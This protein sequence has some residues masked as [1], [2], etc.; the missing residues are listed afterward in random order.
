MGA[1]RHNQ[2][3]I[4]IYISETIADRQFVGQMRKLFG[5]VIA[6]D[7]HSHNTS[8][9]SSELGVDDGDF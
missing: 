9:F 4:L 5:F 7:V 2:N 3:S 8:E 1:R 6:S